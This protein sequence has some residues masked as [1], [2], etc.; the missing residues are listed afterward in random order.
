MTYCSGVWKTSKVQIELECINELMVLRRTRGY[1]QKQKEI[2][3]KADSLFPLAKAI[4]D[5]WLTRPQE[6]LINTFPVSVVDGGFDLIRLE[7]S[8]Y[9][10]GRTNA[11]MIRGKVNQCIAIE[12]ED[13]FSFWRWLMGQCHAVGQFGNVSQAW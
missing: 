5:A 1:R 7:W 12:Q 13:L 11:L 2:R 4:T 10:Y 9:W 3:F 6:Q 8:P